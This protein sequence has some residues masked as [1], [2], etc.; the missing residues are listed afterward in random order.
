MTIYI[1][2]LGTPQNLQTGETYDLYVCKFNE[3]YPIGKI[4][5]QV[6]DTPR[7]ITGIQKVAQLFV[8]LL[9][10][11]KGSD[12]IYPQFGTAFSEYTVG[13]N[14]GSN[15][16]ELTAVIE[17]SVQDAYT[18]AAKILNTT[19]ASDESSLD[20]VNLLGV[21]YTDGMSVFLELTTKAG[22]KGVISLPFPTLDL[23][24]NGNL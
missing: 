5:F 1:S 11:S 23:N 13:A 4:D 17:S 19:S 16:D 2:R 24:I 14:L 3:G 9:L 7:K 10:T 6:G 15:Q 8:K 20:S 12:L 18:Q 22:A 21:D